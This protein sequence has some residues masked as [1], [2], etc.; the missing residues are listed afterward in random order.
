MI[1]QESLVNK[2]SYL[3]DEDMKTILSNETNN[4]NNIEHFSVPGLNNNEKILL[5]DALEINKKSILSWWLK[6]KEMK[7]FY[8]NFNITKNE[9]NESVW[10]FWWEKILEYIIWC[11]R[12]NSECINN[13]TVFITTRFL[14]FIKKKNLWIE[15]LLRIIILLK[16]SVIEHFLD[17]ELKIINQISIIFDEIS[18]KLSKNYNDIALKLL[19]EYTN[20]IDNSNIIT[21]TDVFGKIIH[22]ND[23]FCKLSWY[24]LEELIWK[25]HNIVRHPDM[26]KE[27]FKNM[28]DT[29]QSKKIWKWV[30]KNKKKD[31]WS[32]RVKAT[33]VPIIDEN[34]KIIEYISLRTDITE[35]KEANKNIKE[36]NNA[37]NES[38]MVLKLNKTWVIIDVNDMFSH[39][40]WHNKEEIIWKRFCWA[41][42]MQWDNIECC[43]IPIIDDNTKKNIQ[44]F[45]SQKITWK[46]VIKNR[47]K[48]WH[49]FWTS[50]SIAPILDIND[51]V[52][53][54]VIIQTD[55]T[56]IE[57]TQQ[58]LKDSYNKLKELDIRK[59]EFLNIASHEL[60]TPMTS[61]KWYISMILEWDAWEINDEVRI[62]LEKV[63]W[64]ASR[65][66]ALINDM[67]D[68]SKIESWKQE[69]HLEEVNLKKLL[70]DTFDEMKHLLEEK[71]QKWKTE[72]KFDTIKLKTDENKL[73]QV[74]LNLLWNA[75]KFTPNGWKIQLNS[76]IQDNQIY[77]EVADSWIWIDQKDINKIF[78]KFWQV[79]NSLTRDINWTWLWLP[80][81]KAI[82]EKMWW[83]LKVSSEIWKWSKFM[84]YLPYW[85]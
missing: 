65:L 33:V 32:Y 12:S 75:Q 76:E 48:R 82:I 10:Y 14:D 59:D 36:Y 73:K 16:N 3:D 23:V 28:R 34:D 8:I 13:K 26:P 56:D 45:L 20:A 50:A 2:Y 55:V 58:R 57:I 5:A 71:N 60:R 15:D 83:Y 41:M 7:D 64:S 67:L 66:L 40:A 37:L 17:E 43:G 27:I 70:E 61:V 25:P 51:D 72:I 68:I 42:A 29:I 22:A 69:L 85:N 21:K 19:K 24:T 38:N 46:W 11:L 63:Y 4:I 80:I 49:Y 62:Y 31:G 77:I 79:K 44:R 78:E 53:E 9:I 47:S 1:E 35:L 30:I 81:A 74:L 84:I 6:H 18:T 54:Y 39:M 52:L